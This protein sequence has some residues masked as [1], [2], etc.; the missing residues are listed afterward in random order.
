MSRNALIYYV[1]QL[2]EENLVMT[3]IIKIHK[4]TLIL[5]THKQHSNNSSKRIANRLNHTPYPCSQKKLQI[6]N[7]SMHYLQHVVT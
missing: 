7:E 5:N 3:L 2:P 4:Q 6:E 1:V